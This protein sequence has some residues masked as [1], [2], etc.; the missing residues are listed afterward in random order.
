MP[1]YSIDREQL[2]EAI[3]EQ[4]S[5]HPKDGI[6][7]M[8]NGEIKC[9]MRDDPDVLC[10]LISEK[11][12]GQMLAESALFSYSEKELSKWIDEIDISS[13]TRKLPSV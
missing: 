2:R 13:L 1:E 11:E 3:T 10:E 8:R 7:M 5:L 12:L 6:F 9:A 4:N